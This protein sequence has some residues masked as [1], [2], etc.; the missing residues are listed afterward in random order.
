M[1]VRLTTSRSW[2]LP[3]EEVGFD[4]LARVDGCSSAVRYR[5]MVDALQ[6]GMPGSCSNRSLLNCWV[7]GTMRDEW[8]K[9]TGK[10]SGTM[11]KSLTEG[12]FYSILVL[13]VAA[14]SVIIARD[15]QGSCFGNHHWKLGKSPLAGSM[16]EWRPLQ[17]AVGSPG[18]CLQGLGWRRAGD[19]W[20]MQSALP[21]QHLSAFPGWLA[22]LKMLWHKTAG[23]YP[24]HKFAQGLGV[25]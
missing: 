12:F 17:R 9:W 5:A 1:S 25:F 16:P 4:S 6:L 15:M 20:T 19:G 10:V 22:K 23:L 8:R 14:V 18:L 7:S 11:L 3:C 24:P 21:A 13:F 2:P